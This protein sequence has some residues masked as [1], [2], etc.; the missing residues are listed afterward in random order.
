[1]RNGLIEIK[2]YFNQMQNRYR[3]TFRKLSLEQYTGKWL[4]NLNKK[5][6]GYMPRPLSITIRDAA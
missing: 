1:M 6:A 2:L 4:V 5:K 3:K